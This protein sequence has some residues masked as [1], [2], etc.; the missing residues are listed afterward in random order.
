MNELDFQRAT[1]M[2]RQLRLLVKEFPDL[3]SERKQL[4]YLLKTYEDKHWA[5]AEITDLQI[6]ESDIAERISEKE[7][8]FARRRKDAIRLRLKELELT[9]KELG[10]LLGHGSAS[11]MSELMNGISP[12]TL[13]DLVLIHRLLN[14]DLKLLIPTTLSYQLV[15]RI[16]ERITK[17][18]NPNLK[19]KDKEMVLV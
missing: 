2:D 11:Y 15:G 10:H 13:D 18:N 7:F 16:K 12:F 8:E 1:I 3:A 14:I 17:L 19:F 4:R 5:G 6:T 9:Q